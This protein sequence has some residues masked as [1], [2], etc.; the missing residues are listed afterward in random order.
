[1]PEV[2][3]YSAPTQQ[4]SYSE[5]SSGEGGL[6]S[7]SITDLD[8]ANAAMDEVGR[9]LV[10]MGDA[11]RLADN[12][13]P[14]AYRFSRQGY[15][16]P[17][18]QVPHT[19]GSVTMIPGPSYDAKDRLEGLLA[20][21]DW[22]NLIELGEAYAAE[23]P[24]WLDPQRYIAVALEHLEAFDARSAGMRELASML[25]RAPALHTLQFN[26]N[27][28]LADEATRAWIDDE[29]QKMGGG[30]GDG[31]GGGGGAR[32]GSPLDKAIAEAKN[33]LAN[34]QLVEGLAMIHKALGNVTKPVDRFRGRLE[35]AKLCLQ[36]GQ[37]SIARA[38]LEGLDKLAE[39]HRLS[40]WEPVLCIDLYAAVFTA[41]RAMNQAEEPTPEARAKETAAFERLCQLDAAA[42]LK[43][44]L[45]Q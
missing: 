28:P 22:P 10:R 2:Q 33:L 32:A 8:A 25:T 4:V 5:S 44:M 34:E 43:L 15:W 3:T 13:D 14:N 16:L 11:Y 1:M 26:D 36:G 42:A 38:Q 45:G 40:E 9:I 12:K 35:L 31:G 27:T 30:G 21:E 18:T 6:S 24:L 41:H 29:V 37:M 7:A 20:S 23:G 19:N 17:V 39:H